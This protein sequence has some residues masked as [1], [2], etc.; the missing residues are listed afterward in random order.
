LLLPG[1]VFYLLNFS[2]IENQVFLLIFAQIVP[3]FL[4]PFVPLFYADYVNK[5]LQLLVEPTNASIQ[6]T[7]KLINSNDEDA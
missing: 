3:I 1:G 7:N 4:V 2:G 6:L 5:K